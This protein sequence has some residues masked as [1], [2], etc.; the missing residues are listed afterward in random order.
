MLPAELTSCNHSGFDL[1]P[2]IGR[3]NDFHM[4]LSAVGAGLVSNDLYPL[5]EDRRKDISLTGS[6]TV[7]QP[8]SDTMMAIY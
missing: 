1:R 2:Q 7:P 5:E 8:S 4:R 6:D 3:V